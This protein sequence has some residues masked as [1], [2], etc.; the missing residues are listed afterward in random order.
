MTLWKEGFM[1]DTY[2][3]K[4]HERRNEDIEEDNDDEKFE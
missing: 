4:K 2:L 3:Y 1:D